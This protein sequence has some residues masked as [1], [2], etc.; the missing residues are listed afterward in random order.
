MNVPAA[1]LD[2]KVQAGL[3]MQRQGLYAEAA[4]EYQEVL[5]A[6]P[7]HAGALHL[8]G[9]IAAQ[10]GDPS[11]AVELIGRALRVDP[12]NAAAHGNLGLAQQQCGD[13]AGA[14][15]SLD[16]AV[17]LNA[18]FAE[19]WCNRGNVLR[20][21]GRGDAALASYD[22][23]IR[24]KP[25][26]A[27]AHSNRGTVLN[28]SGQLQAA[29][30]SYDRAIALQPDLADAHSNRGDVLRR[31]QRL[32][33]ALASCNRAIEL[34]PKLA[35]AYSNRG[36]VQRELQQWDGALTS[37]DAALALKP[38][39]AAAHANR[40]I[41]L[42]ER[43]DAAA[44]LAS[45]GRAI[46]L[47]P[48]DAETFL[49][50]ANALTELGRQD[51][52]LGDYNRA[53]ELRPLDAV[54]LGKRGTLF[55]RQQRI[56]TAL[57]DYDRALAIDPTYAAGYV[58]RAMARLVA[59]DFA[60]GWADFEWRWKLSPDGLG[61]RL[62]TLGPEKLWLGEAA[63]AGKTILLH[64]E[65]GLGDTLQF[66]RYAS[67]L[68]EHGANV[69]IEAPPP[70]V[71]LLGSLQGAARVLA[72]GDS[73]PHYDW[74]CPLLSLPLACRT[75]LA[76]IPS[77]IPYLRA[78]ADRVSAWGLRLGPR[79][80]RRVGLVWS[81]G[82]RPDQPEVWSVNARRNIPLRLLAPLRGLDIDFFSLQKG[83]PA[84]TELQRCL[85]EGWDGPVLI[86]HTSELRSFADTAALIEHLDLVISVDTSTVH[87]AGALGK[88]VWMLN[89]FDTCWRW[90]SERTDSPWY[91]TLRIYR[92]PAEGAWEDVVTPV[93]AALVAAQPRQPS[94]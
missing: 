37:C 74:H 9:L 7:R 91:P 53:L 77:A 33:A 64:G 6:Q 1:G 52:A 72:T 93:R 62:Q 59:G 25:T 40:G 15:A 24:R 51:E 49:N 21:L 88:P 4:A 47:D 86:D 35:E 79:R 73:L 11:R 18:G 23:A 44:A 5:R 92:Q 50:R 63:L 68:T 36:I 70:L 84:E 58:N 80:R 31:L 13:L 38:A 12:H 82:F 78:P 17:Q 71:D 32:D 43:G 29:L 83:Q 55:H 75:T 45:Y 76:T 41:I 67:L 16:R 20:E 56:E 46:A 10:T 89:R 54:A 26:L 61:R 39:L 30:A 27:Q 14:L 28:E 2:A 8:L 22:E 65:Q 42:K 34:D 3:A 19:A 87:L 94:A 66:C 48:G 85:A 57:A 81:G 60:G 90:L 69:V